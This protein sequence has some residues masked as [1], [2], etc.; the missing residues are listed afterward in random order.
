[1][2]LRKAGLSRGVCPRLRFKKGE[3]AHGGLKPSRPGRG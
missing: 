3:A 2:L 1:M